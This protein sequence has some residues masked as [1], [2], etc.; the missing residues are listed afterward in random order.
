MIKRFILVAVASLFVCAPAFAQYENSKVSTDSTEV[1]HMVLDHKFFDGIFLGYTTGGGYTFDPVAYEGAWYW[2]NNITVG[3]VITPTVALRAGVQGF[4]Y[5]MFYE[6]GSQGKY[7]VE[8]VNYVFIHQDIMLDVRNLFSKEKKNR[9]WKVG[10]YV[11]AGLL[12]LYNVHFTVPVEYRVNAYDNELAAGGGIFSTLQICPWLCWSVD[13][14]GAMYS[15]RYH[16]WK[17]GGISRHYN[18][19]TGL[20][21][22]FK[23][24]DFNNLSS[25]T[26]KDQVTIS[27]LKAQVK[28]LQAQ[29]KALKAAAGQRAE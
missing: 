20:V 1:D 27:E 19:T 9:M 28:D 25:Y 2:S 17:E 6:I 22:T 5:K 3:K 13:I 21:F 8:N 26:A 14:N 4:N 11:Q 15:A 24:K 16:N 18:F 10:P 7:G 23:G 12:R 29:T